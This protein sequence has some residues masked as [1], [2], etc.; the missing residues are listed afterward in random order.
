[1]TKKT[2]KPTSSVPNG[3]LKSAAREA[4]RRCPR[5]P[6][7]RV[8]KAAALVQMAEGQIW[9]RDPR[10]PNTQDSRSG[11]ADGFDATIA[12]GGQYGELIIVEYTYIAPT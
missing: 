2:F 10:T 12:T 7:S 5:P 9:R 6:K 1:M 8:E 11:Y 3:A 4:Q